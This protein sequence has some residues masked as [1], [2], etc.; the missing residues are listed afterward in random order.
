MNRQGM[1]RLNIKQ[2]GI[3]IELEKECQAAAYVSIPEVGIH[4]P[5]RHLPSLPHNEP[6]KTIVEAK[7]VKDAKYITSPMVGTFYAAPSPEDPPYVKVGERI[8]EGAVI[9]I[10]EAM[11]V[12]NEVKGAMGGTVA[13]IFLRS[14]DP[15]EFGTKIMRI[16]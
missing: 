6:P 3:E 8:E 1:K 11:K 9:G 12:M 13:E 7:E 4:H 2:E 10:I 16:V 15:V 14:G 5:M